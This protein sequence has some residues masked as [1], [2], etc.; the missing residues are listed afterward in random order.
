MPPPAAGPPPRLEQELGARLRRLGDAFQ[1]A[2]ELQVRG[3]HN[4]VRGGEADTLWGG[5]LLGVGKDHLMGGGHLLMWKGGHHF[6]GGAPP[7]VEGGGHHFWGG[8]LLTLKGG[9]PLLGGAPL[10]GG[11]APPLGRSSN[12]PKWGGGL[13]GVLWLFPPPPILFPINK[14]MWGSTTCWG[15]GSK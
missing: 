1:Q 12:P 7:Y 6:W 15:G 3:G 8:H 4:L 9:S 13:H 2:H 14:G 11:G 5:H 10:L